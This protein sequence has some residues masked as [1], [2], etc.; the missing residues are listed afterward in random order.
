MSFLE[1]GDLDTGEGL[2]INA[3]PQLINEIL[4]GKTRI[5]SSNQLA[6]GAPIKPPIAHLHG[7]I[8]HSSLIRRDVSA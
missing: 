1:D 5:N 8:S 2:P 3:S 6:D 7:S 4:L